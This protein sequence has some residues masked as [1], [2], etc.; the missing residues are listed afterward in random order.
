MIEN[1]KNS[2]KPLVIILYSFFTLSIMFKKHIT[3]YL[4]SF[5]SLYKLGPL[6]VSPFFIL[7]YAWEIFN[8][9]FKYETLILII[10]IFSLLILELYSTEPLIKGNKMVLMYLN[11]V[12]ASELILLNATKRHFEIIKFIAT[13]FL[14]YFCIKVLFLNLHYYYDYEFLFTVNKIADLNDNRTVADLLNVFLFFYIIGIINLKKFIIYLVP[15]SF[16]II[17]NSTR[18]VFLEF[19]IIMVILLLI[20]FNFKNII[21]FLLLFFIHVNIF[22]L[23]INKSDEYRNVSLKNSTAAINLC[24]IATCV[25]NQ[26]GEN[27]ARISKDEI[28]TYSRL[29]HIIDTPRNLKDNIFG[30]G[31]HET[32]GKRSLGHTNHSFLSKLLSAYGVFIIPILLIYCYL[33]LKNYKK[34]KLLL[35]LLTSTPLAFNLIF[36][37]TL[38]FTAYLTFATLFYYDNNFNRNK[39]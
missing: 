25:Q 35:V 31:L 30:I 33:I 26:N 11:I 1:F 5:I 7:I 38:S 28:S 27:V 36:N 18:F 10:F 12:I 3:S 9:K 15:I 14:V 24:N 29:D 22:S 20:N 23:T 37:A 32:E 39:E 13:I 34:N 2:L 6:I 16:L 17:I 4:F 19:W 21:L 8:K